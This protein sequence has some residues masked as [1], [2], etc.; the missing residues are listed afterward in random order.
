MMLEMII[1]ALFGALNVLSPLIAMGLIVIAFRFFY[2]PSIAGWLGER[3]VRSSLSSLPPET[4]TVLHD[5]LLPCKDGNTTQIDHIVCGPAGCFVIETKAHAGWIFGKAGDRQWIQSFNKRSKFRFQNPIMQNVRHIN[6]VRH[7]INAPV[8]NVVV[9]V[10]GHFP[11]GRPD[12]V[13]IPGEL[14]HFIRSFE[15]TDTHFNAEELKNTLQDA[16]LTT[17]QA[18][19]THVRR[20]QKKYGG[21]WHTT[22]GHACVA[23]SIIIFLFAPFHSQWPYVTAIS[24]APQH[25][26][27]IHPRITKSTIKQ[28]QQQSRKTFTPIQVIAMSKGHAAIIEEGQIITLHVGQQSPLGWRLE[29]ASTQH[30]DFI[31]PK[32]SRVHYGKTLRKSK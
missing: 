28:P 7:I 15:K 5:V 25:Q 1:K 3:R 10:R 30:A 4:Y 23:V 12:G 20:L 2:W 16:S 27:A 19:K 21:R 11:K 32:G 22:A 26:T 8:H 18:K 17:S 13:F 14:K 24:I 29:D 9:F 6:A 31:N